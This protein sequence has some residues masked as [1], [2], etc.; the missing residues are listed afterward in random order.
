MNLKSPKIRRILNFLKIFLGLPLSIISLSFIISIL[1]RNKDVVISLFVQSNKYTIG[2]GIILLILFIAMRSYAWKRLLEAYGYNVDTIASMFFY[3]TSELK[4]YTPGKIF[5]FV[6]RVSSFGELNIPSKVVLK[7]LIIEAVLAVLSASVISIGV[8]SYFINYVYLVFILILVFVFLMFMIKKFIAD[9]LDINKLV[10]PLIFIIFS[11]VL[12]GLGHY[13]IAISLSFLNPYFLIQFISFF[14]LSWLIGYLFIISPMGLGVRE[15]VIVTGLSSMMSISTASS[16]ALFSRIILI[17]SE[18]LLLFMMSAVFKLRRL[19]KKIRLLISCKNVVILAISI[20]LYIA[21]FSFV[22]FEKHNNFFTGRFD[23]GNM[24]QT[25]WNTINGRIFSLTNPDGTDTISRLAVHADFIL[26]ILSPF[27]LIWQNPKMLLL[28]QTITLALGAI[29]IYLIS[30]EVLKKN[31]LSIIFSLSYLLNPFLQRQNLYDFHAVSLSTTFLLGAFL[32]LIKRNYLIFFL[33]LFLTVLTKEQTYLIAAIFGGYIF[34]A[35]KKYWGILLSIISIIVFYLL[36]FKLIPD[37]RGSDHFAFSYFQEFGT[38]SGDIIKGAIGN[39]V[40]TGVKILSIE[41]IDYFKNLL[42]PV[43]FLPFASPF[44]LIFSLPDFIINILSNNKNLISVNF[45][46]AANILPFV[47]IS[48]IYGA[49]NIVKTQNR[50]SILGLYIIIFSLISTWQFG[51]IPGSKSPSLEVYN[52][53]L[54][55]REEI[56]SFLQTIPKDVSV[57]ATNNLGSHLA[58]RISIYTI[59]IGIDDASY[60]LFLLNDPYAQPSLEDQRKM[61]DELLSS[62]T[63]YK[64]YERDDFIAFKKN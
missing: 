4:R 2:I 30:Y 38:S 44:F 11:Y 27:Y 10:I 24:D 21:Y 51:V 43:G 22:S 19:Q 58:Q 46:Y 3:Q 8:L 18:L 9:Y 15:L 20:A 26:I 29:F 53:R 6:A 52:Q 47:Y 55:Y 12:Y 35:H 28:I 63:Y 23:L 5:S 60:I 14:T 37:V 17:L 16:I 62:K 1:L 31:N 61:V 42:L 49:K 56:E 48:A 39:P 25:V 45:H 57:S 34:F 50:S 41:N 64:V 32:F 7:L 33:F 36:I 54:S 40:N 59:P 13:F